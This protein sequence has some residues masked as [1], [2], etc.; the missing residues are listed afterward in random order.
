MNVCELKPRFGSEATIAKRV[1]TAKYGWFQTAPPEELVRGEI[2]TSENDSE[3]GAMHLTVLSLLPDHFLFVI[4]A[5]R[6]HRL[7]I[8]R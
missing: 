1:A 8:N 5:S 3:T 7:V 2:A 4:S 6:N